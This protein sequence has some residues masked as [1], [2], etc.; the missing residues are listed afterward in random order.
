MAR[1]K[2]ANWLDKAIAE[3]VPGQPPR[4]DFAAWREAHPEALG[5]LAQGET[6][7]AAG[8]P[9]AVE[10]GK[11]IMRSRIGKLAVAA[12]VALTALGV[13]YCLGGSID[14][15][16]K[17]F[18]TVCRNV[19]QSSTVRF[20]IRSGTLTGRVYEKDGYLVRSELQAPGPMPFDTIL[21]DKRAGNYLYMD[22]QRKVAWHP[23]VEIRHVTSHS[24]Y[25]LFTNYQ[26]MPGYSVKKLGKERIGGRLSVGFRLTAPNE[27]SGLLQY[28]IWT[29]PETRLPIR[30]DFTGYTPDG[31]RL[32]QV[33]TDIVFDEP[34]D[35]ALF[36]F[37]S[38]GFEI[39]HEASLNRQE[40]RAQGTVEG[41]PVGTEPVQR[42]LTEP[43]SVGIEKAEPNTPSGEGSAAP[44]PEGTV[45]GV[46]ID[47]STRLPIGGA[48]VSVSEKEAVVTDSE[49]R[50]ELV[51]GTSSSVACVYAIAPGYAVDRVYV[52]LRERTASEVAI[53]LAQGSRLVGRVIDPA[54]QSIEGAEVGAVFLPPGTQSVT[55][56]ADGRFEIEGLDPLVH[57]YY[58]Q[59]VHPGYPQISVEVRPAPA[60]QTQYLDIVLEQGIT[61]F[62]QVTDPN[63]YPVAGVRVGNTGSPV[64]WNCITA[65]TDEQGQ[66]QLEN[67]EPGE[68]LLWATP[69]RYALHAERAVIEPNT[70]F[71]RLDIRLRDPVPLHGLVMSVTEG[72]VA[73]APVMIDTFNNVSNL[74]DE[75]F[76]TGPE[77]WF[78]IPNVPPEGTIS[79]VC[80]GGGLYGS[81]R[82][83]DIERELCAVPVNR[84]G[85]VY[86]KVVADVTGQ[87]IQR[88]T[89]KMSRTQVG[90]PLRGLLGVWSQEGCTFESAHGLFDTGGALSVGGAYQVTVEAEGYDP[91]TLDPV[92][93]QPVREDPNRAVFRLCP[94]T[95]VGGRVVSR[96]GQAI[97]GATIL[98][99]SPMSEPQSKEM[100]P[101]AVTNQS[102]VYSISGLGS[103]PRC[104]FASAT[105]Y[106][107]RVCLMSDLL[108]SA[109]RLGDI[110]LDVS[111]TVVGRVVDENGNGLPK[112]RVHAR[113]DWA[114]ALGIVRYPPSAGP[115]A[116]T[117]SDGR[118]QLSE[119]PTGEVSICLIAADGYELERWSVRLEPGKLVEVNFGDGDGYVVAG[120][121][122]IGDVRLENARVSLRLESSRQ[123]QRRT[124]VEGHFRIGGVTEGAYSLSVL[125]SHSRAGQPN[126]LP[127]PSLFRLEHTLD[128][129]RNMELDI[130]LETETAEEL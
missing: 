72:R 108:Q 85:R 70:T 7:P 117:D 81:S 18:A 47:K 125:W 122:R 97:P 43:E 49:G 65:T 93:V 73:G 36:D 32:E 120:T 5:V 25:E 44:E 27:E 51:C 86:G 33:M 83:F 77:G 1:E 118:Y 29:D 113:I 19:T 88:F 119:V 23:S 3:T 9:V 106:A 50:F 57:S 116:W 104:L 11:W 84:T 54:E 17:A 40:E 114:K 24:V 102:G 39:I 62:G 130:D 30:I 59:I 79:F 56:D 123:Y 103:V 74:C 124:D 22:S 12:V 128:I 112:A 100:F 99:I 52:Q 15:T 26:Q 68:L 109:D 107:P 63:G 105:G 66:Y 60:G 10:L 42:G 55:T 127:R 34:L 46:V 45:T 95:M 71:K 129:H 67:V 37:E 2:Q 92:V 35:D 121:V 38:G 61:V 64:M 111:P 89:V 8:L 78:V 115:D 126:P 69:D 110:V 75:R 82:K 31:Q 87:A 14:G 76:V 53:E 101:R 91:M 98:F 13:I 58:V 20:A 6:Q 80:S 94:V 4:A 90:E 48:M 41:R 28:R 16:S 21:M 96:G